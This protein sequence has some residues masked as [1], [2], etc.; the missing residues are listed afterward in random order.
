[1]PVQKTQK[2][3][4]PVWRLLAIALTCLSATSALGQATEQKPRD[5]E[6]AEAKSGE[7]KTGEREAGELKAGELKFGELAPAFELKGLDDKAFT[8]KDF[9]KSATSKGK[10]VVIVFVRAHW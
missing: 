10:N 8:L 5:A 7:L 6:P 9:R 4:R 3:R 1:M 2:D